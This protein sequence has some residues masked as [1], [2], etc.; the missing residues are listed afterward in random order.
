MYIRSQQRVDVAKNRRNPLYVSN[1]SCSVPSSVRG[2]RREL[3]ESNFLSRATNALD[4]GQCA[5][6]T[7]TRVVDRGK[8][9]GP[10]VWTNST[11]TLTTQTSHRQFHIPALLSRSSPSYSPVALSS[12]P[13]KHTTQRQRTH[14]STVK[15]PTMW[16]SDTQ[17]TTAHVPWPLAVAD[18]GRNRRRLLFRG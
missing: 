12:S 13:P 14:A 5:Q 3:D 7:E 18:I 17:S 11:R 2:G 16:L 9:N 1:A 8:G 4:Q 6:T 10:R 15:M